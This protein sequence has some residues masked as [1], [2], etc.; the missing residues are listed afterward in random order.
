MTTRAALRQL[1]DI[2]NGNP[3]E[4]ELCVPCQNALK[5]ED[6]DRI[7]GL[8]W[9]NDGF[10]DCEHLEK[11]IVY[12]SLCTNI[13]RSREVAR[14]REDASNDPQETPDWTI[15]DSTTFIFEDDSYRFG[16]EAIEA[17][18][19]PEAHSY[20]RIIDLAPNPE[21]LRSWI[22][23]CEQDHG[24]TC[25]SSLSTFA[26]VNIRFIDVT[27]NCIVSGSLTDRYFALSYVWG[28]AVQSK[29]LKSNVEEMALPNAL[30]QVPLPQTIKDSMTLVASM[31]ERH[32]WI[33]ALCIV[34][35]DDEG[36]GVQI[37]QMASI[38]AS[39]LTTIVALSGTSAGSGLPGISSSPARHSDPI[40]IAPG[41]KIA[42][43]KEFSELFNDSVYNSRAWTY[44]E[45]SLSQ[46]C[47]Y[48]TEQQIYYQCLTAA[49]CEDRFDH[50][51]EDSISS[52]NPL[53]EARIWS[54]HPKS[55]DDLAQNGAFRYYSRFIADY[56]SKNMGY[57]SD[58]LNA[59]KGISVTLSTMYGWKF[60]E[61]MPDSLIDLAL[62]WTPLETIERRNVDGVFPFCSASWAGWVGKV[63][64]GD[65]V[66]S[67]PQRPLLEGFQSC[68]SRLYTSGQRMTPISPPWAR[69]ASLSV[70]SPIT[71]LN[72]SATGPPLL[73]F[74]AFSVPTGQFT[75]KPSTQRLLNPDSNTSVTSATHFVY[76]WKFRRCGILYGY[77]HTNSNNTDLVLLSTFSH[78]NTLQAFGPVIHLWT[79]DWVGRNERLFDT[80]FE[81]RKWCTLNVLVIQWEHD[82]AYRVG[83]GQICREVWDS[84]S[85]RETDVLL[86]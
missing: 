26:G 70:A 48:F 80:A 54:Q 64:Y 55:N 77:S 6:L 58:I 34:Q 67:I 72:T 19:E 53:A 65:M 9:L 3:L 63:H 85:P 61:A 22:K 75:I 84:C 66:H 10:P 49:F 44:Q 71:N 41:L 76:D 57:L 16:H 8:L 52:Q 62:L 69:K 30:S 36:K 20:V 40:R 79:E 14:R 50:S 25:N 23:I 28:T 59:F 46:R 51:L 81:D 38:Y 18:F 31:G 37:G 47:L 86:G 73:A 24:A 27:K 13:I 29:L 12:C 60:W 83:I 74:R 33:D 35:D 4:A 11:P 1:R 7:G 56:S 17:K 15:F 68:V 32:L 2:E 43:R 21:L 5:S 45:Q 39:A 78:A 42:P 82:V